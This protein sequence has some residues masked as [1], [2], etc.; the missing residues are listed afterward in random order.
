[1]A[2]QIVSD[3][4]GLRHNYGKPRMDLLP[5]DVLL[6][7]A[8]VYTAAIGKYPA[9]NWE[10]GMKWGNVYSSLQRHLNAFWMGESRDKESGQ[11]HIMHALWNCVALAAYQLRGIGEDDRS[12]VEKPE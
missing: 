1:M 3:G 10:R 7:L 4:G 12:V 2:E 8:Q 6:E 5:P 9:R 11:Q